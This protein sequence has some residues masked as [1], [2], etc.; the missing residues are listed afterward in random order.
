MLRYQASPV[1]RTRVDSIP[2][3]V[4]LPCT[5]SRSEL[6]KE[7]RRHAVVSMRQSGLLP[8]CLNRTVVV[9]YTVY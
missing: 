7:I 3:V 9:C 2:V 5:Q 4:R 8:R 6:P 1:I